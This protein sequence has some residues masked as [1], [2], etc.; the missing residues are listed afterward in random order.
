[1]PSVTSCSAQEISETVGD[2]RASSRA[3]LIRVI[4]P[5]SIE[6]QWDV[7]ALEKALAAELHS[8]R[9]PLQQWLAA[10]SNMTPN[11]CSNKVVAEAHSAP[12]G[13]SRTGRLEGS[14]ALP[15]RG[16]HAA[17][18]RQPLARAPG[19]TR[20]SAPVAF[21]CGY[22]EKPQAGVQNARHSICLPR[23]WKH[24]RDVIQILMT[25]QTAA[26]KT[27]K[28]W[29]RPIMRPGRSISQHAGVQRPGLIPD[30]SPEELA[31]AA[32]SPQAVA[33]DNNPLRWQP[34]RSQRPPVRVAQARSTSSAT[35]KLV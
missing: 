9:L 12:S 21:I 34:C 5:Q 1:M 28:P 16:C 25:V 19:F 10:D 24:R 23:C 27:S 13:Q 7:L 11:A 33:S 17:E 22:A 3:C 14:H 29:K 32:S 4:P 26:K 15:E 2:A 6:K 20:P 35:G 18:S 30:A 8:S 31:T